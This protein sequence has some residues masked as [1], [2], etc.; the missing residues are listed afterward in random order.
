MIENNFKK[1]KSVDG[2]NL[3]AFQDILEFTRNVSNQAW[4][5]QTF[6]TVESNL[7]T[8]PLEKFPNKKA[9]KKKIAQVHAEFQLNSNLIL[10]SKPHQELLT[11]FFTQIKTYLDSCSK[12]EQPAPFSTEPFKESI[13]IYQNQILDKIKSVLQA[14]H[15]RVSLDDLLKEKAPPANPPQN[16]DQPSDS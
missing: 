12:D 10:K 6:A 9:C 11:A 4:I 7:E 8:I 1:E 3:K 2:E 5:D 16:Q 13:A 15:C 14:Q